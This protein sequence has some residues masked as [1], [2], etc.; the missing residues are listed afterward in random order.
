[1]T[2]N[3]IFLVFMFKAIVKA[4]ALIGLSI[5]LISLIGFIKETNNLSTVV[6]IT[7]NLHKYSTTNK[8]ILMQDA[9]MDPHINGL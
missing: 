5:S 7:Q 9:K 8:P 2:I 3:P 6:P 1:M 4:F